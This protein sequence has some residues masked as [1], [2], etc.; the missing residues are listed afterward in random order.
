MLGTNERVE[1]WF[2]WSMQE[3]HLDVRPPDIYDVITAL[4]YR[5]AA[6]WQIEKKKRIT[7][8]AN[9]ATLIRIRDSRI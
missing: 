8:G 6:L 3:C 9:H 4:E 2:Q 1:Q 5:H 7:A